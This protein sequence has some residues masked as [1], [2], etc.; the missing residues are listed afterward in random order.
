MNWTGSDVPVQL[1]QGEYRVEDRKRQRER[2]E[3]KGKFYRAREINQ[4]ACLND[5]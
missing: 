3:V 5:K 1:C 4:S 2:E